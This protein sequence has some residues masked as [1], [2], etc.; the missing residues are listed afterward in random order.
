MKKYLI[1]LFVMVA[2]LSA[3]KKDTFDESA[4][5]AK[6]DAQIREYLAANK[7]TA[8]ADPSGIYYKVVTP[9]DSNY[10]RASSNV[11]VEYVGKLMSDGTTFDSN[12]TFTTA[13]TSVIRGWTIGLQHI[14]VGGTIILY[15][16]SGLAYGNSESGAIPK[17]AVLIFTITLTSINS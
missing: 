15:I 5:A 16:P 9:G 14:G 13:L 12:T 17:N 4:Q 3:C 11:T 1:L 8:V 6:D 7:I 2:S 10:P